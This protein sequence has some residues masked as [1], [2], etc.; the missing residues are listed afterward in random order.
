MATTAQA[1]PAGD[2]LEAIRLRLVTAIGLDTQFVRLVAHD[3][4]Q[5]SFEETLIAIR[6]LGPRPRPYAGYGRHLRP[7]DRSIRVYIHKR[8]SLDFAGDDRLLMA[9]LCAIED[10]VYN[11]LDDWTITDSRSVS[12]SPEVLH[13]I[14]ASNGPPTRQPVNDIGECFSRLDFEF[15][16]IQVNETPAP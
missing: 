16:Y 11:F 7:I 15:M 3:N 4:Y 1:Y 9:S 13:P 6:P 2:I 12:L 14:D 8:S 10:T 5:I